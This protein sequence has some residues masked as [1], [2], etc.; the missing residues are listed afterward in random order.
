VQ[1]RC[2]DHSDS[3]ESRSF[4]ESQA[5]YF[6]ELQIDSQSHFVPTHPYGINTRCALSTAEEDEDYDQTLLSAAKRK[7]LLLERK[8]E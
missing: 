4:E 6:S 5:N 7:Q 8:I 2:G 1:S 3:E